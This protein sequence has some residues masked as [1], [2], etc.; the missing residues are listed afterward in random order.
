MRVLNR[1]DQ[2]CKAANLE[3]GHRV[4]RLPR[5]LRDMITAYIWPKPTS[6]VGDNLGYHLLP[7][8]QK[9][10]KSICPGPPCDC[11]Q[12]LPHLINLNFV[13]PG[14]AREMLEHVKD[15][16]RG[17][18][19]PLLRI[20]GPD[21]EK[22]VRKDIFH[23][24]VPMEALFRAVDFELDIG[25]ANTW[26][27]FEEVPQR[28]AWLRD[29]AQLDEAAKALQSIPFEVKQPASDNLRSHPRMIWVYLHD[30]NLTFYDFERLLKVF[31]PCFAKMHDKGFEV[32]L[33]FRSEPDM[34]YCLGKEAWTWTVSEWMEK[35][36]TKNSMSASIDRFT[37]Q[38]EPVTERHIQDWKPRWELIMRHFYR[39]NIGG[40]AEEE[41]SCTSAQVMQAEG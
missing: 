2:H 10:L 27:A 30:K 8:C 16:M 34:S 41:G 31:G 19:L 12:G 33:D 37:R 20:D 35:L 6:T 5:E 9:L 11:M 1:I 15:S 29:V 38:P 23:V 36:R 32:I 40:E 28:K 24:G 21:I 22:Y 25:E 13:G 18:I 39:V 3:I 4:M 17:Q 7:A 26:S 14:L